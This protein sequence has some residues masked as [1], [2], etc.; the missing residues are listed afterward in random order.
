MT[1]F[2][3]I[4]HPLILVRDL[5]AA[6]QRY[7]AIG[8]TMTPPGK[9][10][11]GTSTSVA[12]L[13]DCLVEI[14]SIYDES[15]L[16]EKPAGGFKFGRYI[17]EH[18]QE[19]E[20]ASICALHSDNAVEDVAEVTGR[21]IASQGTIDFGRDVVLPDGSKDR[22]STTLKVLQDDAL[23]RI[24]NFICQQH[25]PDLIYIPKWRQHANGA[26]GYTQVSILAARDHQPAVR[27][28]LLGLYGASA[29][30]DIPGGFAA[31]TGQGS[32]AVYDHSEFER[33]YAPLPEQLAAETTPTYA[34]LH[35]KV[36]SL[37]TVERILASADVAFRREDHRILLTD[38]AAFGNMFLNFT[39]RS[40]LT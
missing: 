24:S 25:R 1:K 11:W 27:A 12:I 16:D 3:G 34:A 35:I 38:A 36:D 23:P 9:H 14:M 6:R 19:H 18:L 5:A 13:D 21:G 15:L 26:S 28:R 31:A 17:H 4:D 37:S 32:F 33:R 40:T 29:V 22:T 7:E 10:P 20:G 8:F 39:D 30:T 2:L